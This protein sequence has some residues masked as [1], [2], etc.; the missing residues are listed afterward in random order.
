MIKLFENNFL[1]KTTIT[2]NK[3][4]NSVVIY[5]RLLVGLNACSNQVPEK[6]GVIK[7]NSPKFQTYLNLQ[8]Y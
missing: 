3:K 5:A 6:R 8:F 2:K 1:L 7:V 4:T